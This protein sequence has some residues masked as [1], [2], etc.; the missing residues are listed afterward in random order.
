MEQILEYFKPKTFH[1]VHYVGL[2][3]WILI[4]IVFFAILFDMENSESEFD[5]RCSGAKSEN[6]DAVRGKCYEKYTK[7]HNRF[8]FPIFGSVISNLFILALVC[9]IYSQIVRPKVDQLSR[10]IHDVGRERKLLDQETASSTGNKLFI[11]YCCQLWIRIVLGV[12]FITLQTRLLYPLKFPSKF[13]CYLTDGTTQ[14]RNSSENAQN[15]T[16]H[17]CHNQ[18]AE[19]KTFWMYAVLSVNGILVAG[20]LLETVYLFSR[21]CIERSFMQDSKFLKIH[22]NQRLNQRLDGGNETI[23]LTRRRTEQLQELNFQEFIQHSKDIIIKETQELSELQSPFSDHLGDDTIAKNLTLDQ[24]YTNLVVVKW[25]ETYDF[26]ENREEQLKIYP[27]SRDENPAPKSPEDLLNVENKKVLIVGRP[28]IGKTLYCI[29]LLRDWALG[30]V[31]KA[32]SG[33]N[34]NFYVAFFV[35]FSKFNSTNNLSLRELLIESEYFPKRHMDDK[36][37][38]YL[39]NNPD[40]VLILFDGF[41]EFKHDGNITEASL[42]PRSI[43]EKKPLYILYQWLVTGKLLKGA[44][45]LTTTRATALWGLRHLPFDKAYEIL[46]FSVEQVQEYVNKFAGNDKKAGE[47]LWRHISS[48]INLLSFCYLPENSFI[49]CLSLLKML[50]FNSPALADVTLPSKLTMIYNFAVKMFYVKRTKAFRESF[51]WTKY[52]ESDHLAQAMEDEF[53]RL[54]IVAFEGVKESRRVLEGSELIGIKDSAFFHQLPNRQDG[55]LDYKLFCFT[56]LTIQ[57]FFAARHMSNNMSETEL[58]AFVS[59]NI[60]NGKWQLVF[61]FLAGLMENKIHLPS[62]IITDLLPV[63]TEEEESAGY[64]EQWTENE[65]KRKVTSW[66]TRNERHLAVTLMKCLNENARMMSEAQRKLQQINFDFVTFTDCHLTPVEC[67]SLVNTI[68]LQQISH[69]DLSR[70]NIGPLGCLEIL[71]LLKCRESQLIWLSLIWNQLTDEAVKYL[72]EA[73]NNNNCRLRTLYLSHNKISNIGAQ[74]LAEAINS[75]NCQLHTLNLAANNISDTGAQHLA[76]A[77]NNNSCQ[78]HTLD[79]SYSNIS[80]TGI[81]HLAEAI[82]SNNCQLHTLNLSANNISDTGAQHLAE[83]INNNN[84]QLRTLNLSTNKVTDIGAQHLAKAINSKNCQLHTLDLSLNE[85]I[86]VAGKREARNLPS[87]RQSECKQFF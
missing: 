23:P 26:T 68:N 77:I 9:V 62:E 3:F 29:R 86:T 30:K 85:N 44:S 42:H 6:V 76:E 79:L 36:V 50:Q 73:I 67:S 40:G 52:L 59:E 1:R 2:V 51:T 37:W 39:L 19:K 21:A 56:H 58:K 55:L 69:L 48:N 80:N 60:K 87:N 57:E 7:Q 43:E 70:N 61:Q 53:E 5:F 24:I 64:N 74:Y 22:L 46:G 81:Q 18:R 11:A 72:S 16:L 54:G 71:K 25:R 35:K 75:N 63:K 32:T 27:R 65:E 38:N 14:P 17:D 66:P 15:S 20:I 10:G 82:N 41:D 84:C 83:A 8:G 49:I 45:A 12:I 13:N 78:L 31:F 28:G 34:I 33:A 4:S 47:R